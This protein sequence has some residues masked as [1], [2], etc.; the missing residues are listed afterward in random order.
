VERRK[1]QENKAFTQNQGKALAAAV[2]P[3]RMISA[4]CRQSFV[5]PF[6]DRTQKGS[7]CNHCDSNSLFS[8]GIF[9]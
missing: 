7:A 9:Q 2:S 8:D 6:L 3:N 5:A 4:W 1:T